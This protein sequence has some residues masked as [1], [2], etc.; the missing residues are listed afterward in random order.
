MLTRTVVVIKNVKRIDFI[1][2]CFLERE[3]LVS[4]S[5]NVIGGNLNQGKYLDLTSCLSLYAC[6]CFPVI[7]CCSHYYM[8]LDKIAS[9]ERLGSFSAFALSKRF[10]QLHTPDHSE[11]NKS[12]KILDHL[13]TS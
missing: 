8:S 11:K 3:R 10:Q 9:A 4:F 1:N 12:G 13:L 7:N 2:G 5:I 6:T